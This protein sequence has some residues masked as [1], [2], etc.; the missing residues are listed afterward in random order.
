MDA[1]TTQSLV[2]TGSRW[3]TRSFD[4]PGQPPRSVVVH[5]VEAGNARVVDEATGEAFVERIETIERQWSRRP[6]IRRAS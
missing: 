1:A 6:A 5:E 4:N 2:R 3:M